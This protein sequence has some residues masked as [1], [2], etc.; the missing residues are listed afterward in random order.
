MTYLIIKVAVCRED[1]EITGHIPGIDPNTHRESFGVRVPGEPVV[2]E[3]HL[4]S[5]KIHINRTSGIICDI[6]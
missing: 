4:R 6:I 3:T 1:P 2:E 5:D